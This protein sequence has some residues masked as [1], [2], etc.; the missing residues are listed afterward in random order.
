MA[1][2]SKI[3]DE[4]PSSLGGWLFA[5]LFL[6]LVVIGLAG[7]TI[8]PREGAPQVTTRSAIN[9]DA[10][11]AT[12]TGLLDSG[13]NEATAWFRW[14]TDPKLNKDVQETEAAESPVASKE[15]GV[16]ISASLSDLTPNQT[17]YFQAKAESTSGSVSGD[18][19][20]F[21]TS[22]QSKGQCS[23][24]PSFIKVPFEKTYT[25]AEVRRQLRSD[26]QRWV[27]SKGFVRPK[28]AVAIVTGWSNNPAGVDGANRARQFYNLVMTQSAG[29]YFDVNTAL[30]AIQK[31]E[32][33]P[34]YHFEV[35]LFFVEQAEEC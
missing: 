16:E 20:S 4:P 9:L 27:S 5:D 19:R 17:Y 3:A 32:S 33:L 31:S 10:T 28:V 29:E 18:I 12:I 34:D 26:I 22:E 7:F 8:T 2:R 25:D 24:A 15:L 11:T 13:D 23:D 35:Q 1:L 14:G 6:L 30:R 21:K